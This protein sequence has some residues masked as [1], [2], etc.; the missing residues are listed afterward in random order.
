MFQRFLDATDYWFGY[1]DDSSVGSY[2]PAWE[3]CVVMTSNQANAADAA[4]AGDGEVPT[5][6]GTGPRLGAEPSA[7]PPSPPRGADV[8]AQLAQARELE[9]K[10]AE[11]YRAV[12][13]LRASIA[14]EASAHGERARELGRQARD[15]INADFNVDDPTTPPRASQKLIVAATLLRAMPTPSMPE[16]RNLHREAQALIEQV[17][18]QQAESSASRIRQQGSA[19]D[20]RG[21]KGPEPSV[22]TG[23]A[24]ERPAN[25][26]RTPARERLLDTRGQAQDGDA[27]NV[28]NARRTSNAE[29]RAAAGYHPRRG[30]R[31]DSREDR[32][33][34]PEPPGTRVFSREIHTASF[35]QRFRQTTTI[36]KYNGATD[37]RV[38]LN[39]YRLACQLGGATNDEVIIRNLPLHLADSA[40]TWLEHLPAS[41]IHNWDD[42]VRTFVGNFQGM[43]VRPGNSWDLRSCTQK[44]GESLRDFIRRSSKRCTELPSVARSEIMHAF[45]EGTTCRDLVRELGRSPPVDS[46][47]MF[48]IATSFA[49][50]EEAVGA[51]FDGKKGKRVDDAPAEGSKSKEPHQK[52]KRGKNGKKPR[53]EARE[54]G[55]DDGGDEALAVYPARRGPRPAPRGPGVFDDML[56]KPCPYHKTP[57]NHTLEKCDM[58]KRFYGRAAAKDGEAKKDRGDGDTGGFPAVENVFLIFG[59]PTV[60]MS[61]RQRKWERH[62][63]L[64]AEKAPPSFLDWSE[65]AITFS[66][67][68]HP[69]R[70]PNPGQY[71]LVVDPVI[72]NA[73]FSKVLM[74][75]GSSLNILYV[76]TL[77]LLGIGLDQLRPSTTSFYAV[78]PGKRVQPLG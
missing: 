44:P 39:D 31:Y 9:A 19:R 24:V 56:K 38:W 27:R 70:I 45:L 58:L 20:D 18:V 49:S 71:P 40:R 77:R 65:D 35:P 16:A 37:P 15:R 53:R 5:G 67:E 69:N 50:G 41:Q 75:G 34:T 74:D 32:S 4:E 17:A 33:P 26:G 68:D 22:H 6:P 8:N 1:S 66:R 10:L 47:E 60:D 52:N 72:G 13:L 2:D 51:I 25:P 46:N 48:D 78:A 57:I 36:V 62:E 43:Y 23:G 42:L 55:H 30:G 29:A 12:Q 14:G 61:S 73:R 64:A 21:A 59:G 63:V 54:Q 7:P 3:C 28:I 11:E 76:H